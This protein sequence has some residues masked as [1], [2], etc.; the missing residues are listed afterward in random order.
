MPVLHFWCLAVLLCCIFA[1]VLT[2]CLLSGPCVN[3][4]PLLHF[5]SAAGLLCRIWLCCLFVATLTGCLLWCPYVNWLPVLHFC[6]VAVLL[7][8][9]FAATLTGCL[10]VGSLCYL[11]ACIAFLLRCSFAMLY[12]AVL[13]F[14]VLPFCCYV[15]WLPVVASLC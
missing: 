11:V 15:N 8:C 10:F 2:G 6:C 7:C 9:I 13:H 5:C 4:W 1:A 14:A 3:W 12:F